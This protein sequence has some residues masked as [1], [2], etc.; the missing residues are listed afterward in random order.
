MQSKTE[1]I[2]AAVRRTSV[3]PTRLMRSDDSDDVSKRI[4]DAES[5]LSSN[6]MFSVAGVD[7]PRTMAPG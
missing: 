2:D 7:G 4:F 5:S 3:N 6:A 1:S